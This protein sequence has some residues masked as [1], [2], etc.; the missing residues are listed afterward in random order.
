MPLHLVSVDEHS[1]HSVWAWNLAVRCW[2]LMV[3]PER[4]IGLSVLYLCAAFHSDDL[5]EWCTAA[6][7]C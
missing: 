3:T 2:P 1:P 7:F 5:P 4:C 6:N